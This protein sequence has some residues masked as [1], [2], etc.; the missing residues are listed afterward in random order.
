MREATPMVAGT[1]VSHV[2]L[3]TNGRLDIETACGQPGTM[4]RGA[5]TSS[6]SLSFQ[7]TSKPHRILLFRE[8]N[9]SFSPGP[10]ILARGRRDYLLLETA[11]SSSV[12]GQT[13]I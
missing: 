5:V 3:V 10:A 11:A 13:A 6:R 4:V 7:N 2:Q 1:S 12:D 8:D 9:R